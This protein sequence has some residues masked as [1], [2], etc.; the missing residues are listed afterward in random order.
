VDETLQDTGYAFDQNP[1][2]QFDASLSVSGAFDASLSLTPPP[3]VQPTPT[4]TG[5]YGQELHDVSSST[6]DFSPAGWFDTTLA[7][8]GVFDPFLGSNTT[9]RPPPVIIPGFPVTPKFSCKRTLLDLAETYRSENRPVVQ[10]LEPEEILAQII[11]ATEYLD[12]YAELEDHRDGVKACPRIRPETVLNES[13]VALIW[14][15]FLLY[16]ERESVLYAEASRGLGLD[17][18]IRPSSEIAQ[19]IYQ[20]EQE[21]GHKA[22]YS[23]IVNIW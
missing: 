1:T 14:P 23:D 13:E 3:V 17:S 18:F 2:S 22:F 5:S 12:G 15:L 19:D 4:P 7:N 6:Y 20:V 11:K 8:T 10:L 21:W 16:C 9:Q